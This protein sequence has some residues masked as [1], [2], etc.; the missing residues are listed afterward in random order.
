MSTSSTSS[1]IGASVTRVDGRLK[2]TGAARYAVDHPIE[3][4]AYGYGVSSTI[5]NGKITQIDTSA[6]ERMPGV[7]AILH[8]GN[9]DPLFRTAGPLQ[10]NSRPSESRP[11]F[12]DDVVYYY[13]QFVALVVANTFEQAQD[14]AFHVKVTYDEKKP[15][16]HLD[17]VPAPAGPPVKNYTRGKADE[18]FESAPVKIDETYI[19]P[20][21][22]H[23]PMEMHGTI[24]VWNGD[25]VTLYETSQGVMNH[26]GVMS[27]MLGVPLDRVQVISP[28]CG[29]GFG[30]K[31]FP[32]P[33]SLLAAMAA[34]R[35]DRPVKVSVPRALMFTTVG[36]RP[37]T[38]QRVRLGA[39]PDGKLTAIIHDVLNHTSHTDDIMENCTEPTPLLYSCPN[40]AAAQ[41]L[42]KLNVGTPTPMRGP[43][44]CPGLFA[45]E[46]A[47]D[48]LAVK[49]KIDPLDLRLR[50]Y[51]EIDESEGHPFSSKHLREAYQAGAE[52]FGWSKRTPGIGSMR[53]GDEILGWGV[54]T[55]TWSAGRG[56]AE[57]RV[58]LM[59]DGT[60]RASSA[61]QDIGT[62]TYTVFAQVV[63]DKTGIPVERIEVVLG[64]S[65][66]PPGPTSGGSTATASV[67]PAIS[68]ASTAAIEAL[69][70]ASVRA[71]QSPFKGADPATLAMTAGRVHVKEKSPETG[72]PFEQIL[73]MSR[74]AALEGNGKSVPS[75]EAHKV[76][77]QSFG[78]H[79]VEVAWDPGIA[80]LRVSRVLS[81]FDVGRV[82]NQKTARNQILGAV[83][84]G[85]GMGMFEE[86][87]YDPRNGKPINNNFADYIVSTNADIPELDC[88]F[89]DY[90]D[91]AMGEYGA[92][93]IGEIGLTG[94]APA[95]A[96]A[97][98]H[99]TGVRVRELPIRIE[100]LMQRGMA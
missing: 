32:W 45:L 59:A 47:L 23:N 81:V 89:L 85:I 9:T 95:M 84:M 14:A 11:P 34:R 6:A 99:A 44:A 88:I 25:K 29:S 69:L 76:T 37:L 26:Q 33:H 41:R 24:A 93:G 79:F 52:R 51:A 91:S 21:E 16:V 20:V 83:V 53:K 7:L 96:M 57:V 4:V 54:G 75:H 61:T 65:S 3:N 86:T 90:P 15:L 64:D 5:A 35:L 63:S 82:I 78:A 43:G 60:A 55:A 12:E 1:V 22:T 87:I 72:I 97:T 13:G 49:M 17:D 68:A 2:V 58:R 19:T 66:L 36:H 10:P 98:Y 100:K 74:L 92:R 39:T 62:G 48:E 31:L 67:L 94:V 77:A 56:A 18:A 8:H 28:F 38:R 30:G 40:V 46:S 42:V 73:K 80:R 71:D 70:K 27:E 50:N